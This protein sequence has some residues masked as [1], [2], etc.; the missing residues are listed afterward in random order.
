MLEVL[1]ETQ[2]WLRHDTDFFALRPLY[3][4]V[5]RQRKGRR[6]RLPNTVTGRNRRNEW[7]PEEHP[8]AQPLHYRWPIVWR[9]LGDLEDTGG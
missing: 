9:L 5:E 8:E 3:E 1:T 6:A 4:R 7:L 2:Q